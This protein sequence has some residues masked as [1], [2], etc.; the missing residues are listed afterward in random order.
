MLVR[1]PHRDLCKYITELWRL[2]ANP[3]SAFVL[4]L[5]PQPPGDGSPHPHT[6]RYQVGA[7][8]CSVSQSSLHPWGSMGSH[9]GIPSG[10]LLPP[11]SSA[12]LQAALIFRILKTE[13]G[14]SLCLHVPSEPRKHTFSSLGTPLHFYS[15]CSAW[16]VG[17]QSPALKVCTVFSVISTEASFPLVGEGG[18]APY[19]LLVL[20]NPQ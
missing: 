8:K 11:S 20:E 19:F 13:A 7:S 18:Q 10:S 5:H 2:F 6:L 15:A 9:T 14:H 4:T 17:C 1:Q 16:A 12:L 3:P